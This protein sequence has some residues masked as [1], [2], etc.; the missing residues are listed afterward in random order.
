MRPQGE[1]PAASLAGWPDG[2]MAEADQVGCCPVSGK[3]GPVS[4]IPAITARVSLLSARSTP[5]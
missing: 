4:V 2:R 3:V 5:A 1:R